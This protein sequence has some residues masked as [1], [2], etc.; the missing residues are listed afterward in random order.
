MSDQLDVG[1][2]F[3]DQVLPRLQVVDVP[4]Q[5]VVPVVEFFAV[6]VE[7]DRDQVGLDADDGADQFGFE[8]AGRVDFLGTQ[9]ADAAADEFVC[10]SWLRSFGY[11]L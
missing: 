3:L 5:F 1:Q 11:R 7:L 4:V 2:E 10:A 6:V 8:D 9:Q